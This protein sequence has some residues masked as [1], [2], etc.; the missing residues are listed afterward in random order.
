MRVLLPSLLL[1]VYVSSAFAADT[2]AEPPFLDVRLPEG[3]KIEVLVS[4]LSSARGMALSD[5]NTLFV[6]T[7]RKGHVY[8]VSNV[9]SETRQIYTIAEERK[10]PSGIALH[11]GDLY[12]GEVTQVVRFDDIEDNL[13]N[14]GEP[15]IVVGDFSKKM[16]HGW[17]H[18]QI[19]PDDKLYVPQG[20]PCN[21]C[22]LPEFGV[23]TRYELD[24]SEPE[25][26]ARGIRNSVGMAWH[27]VT[28]ELWF[29]D[30]GR[31][32]LGDDI[33]P[34]ELNRVVEEGAH[35]GFP[36][37]HGGTIIEPDPK[38]AGLGSCAD[39]VAPVQQLGP[40]VAALQLRFYTGD[41]FPDEYRNQIFIAE[42]G[43]WDRSEKIGYRIMLVRLD[44]NKAVSY[45]PFAEGWLDSD[46]D[47]VHGRPV[48]M[49]VAPD[50]SLL[51][52]DDSQGLI[53][54]ISYSAND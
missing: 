11:D 6:G 2:P 4:G 40:H 34:D 9:F 42:H 39:S 29:T 49:L 27:P 38:L 18:I 28:G 52:S 20:S 37:C 3:F 19:G 32:R 15:E 5:D 14:P 33:P 16:L 26:V 31:D 21:A 36:F 25:V 44:G 51:V 7:F 47:T 10:L 23:I 1:A 12:V 30:N 8:A 17:K 13:A 46:G 22:D 45:E 24:G 48:D 53:Y 43:S 50:G 41:M 35:F 54:R